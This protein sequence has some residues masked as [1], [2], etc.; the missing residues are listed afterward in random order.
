MI[1]G[2]SQR[3]NLSLTG[4]ICQGA[5]IGS[6][7]RGCVIAISGRQK[8]YQISFEPMS[9]T[10]SGLRPWG[11]GT[12][13]QENTDMSLITTTTYA[14]PLIAIW[15]ALWIG[16]TS[17]RS[18]LNTSI[19]DANSPELLQKI[20]RHGNFIEW[21]PFVLVLM[22]LAEAQGAGKLWLH[23]AGML[24]LIGRIAHPFGLKI[25]NANH[26]LRYVG[27]GTNILA[28]AILAVALARIVI[29]F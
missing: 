2:A 10:Q 21:V 14:L 19:G 27:N 23:A 24:L 25:D 6:P 13:K 26:P 9:K 17:T 16:V 4:Q 18:A 3:S 28:T 22:I 15:F 11:I 8:K 7:E 29:G 1:V 12:Q 5:P 20:R